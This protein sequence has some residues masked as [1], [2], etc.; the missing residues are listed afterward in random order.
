MTNPAIKCHSPNKSLSE[1]LVSS[2]RGL[3]FLIAGYVWVLKAFEGV[4]AIFSVD[5]IWK[6]WL[7]ELKHWLTHLSVAFLNLGQV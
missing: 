3:T 5:Q 4:K 1:K 7:E 2:C 6:L